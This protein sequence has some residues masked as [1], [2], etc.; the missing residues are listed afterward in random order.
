MYINIYGAYAFYKV[1]IIAIRLELNVIGD[2]LQIVGAA[3]MLPI[4]QDACGQQEFV[5]L[6]VHN[7]EL[8][9]EQRACVLVDLRHDDC[10]VAGKLIERLVV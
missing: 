6:E 9:I 1:R 4:V 8:V 10:L 3:E 5:V 7:A 2:L